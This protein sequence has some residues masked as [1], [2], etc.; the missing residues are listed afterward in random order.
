M[1]QG[2]GMQGLLGGWVTLHPTSGFPEK[3]GLQEQIGLWF[4]DLQSVLDPQ[5][6]GHTAAHFRLLGSQYLSAPQS[7]LSEHSS[8]QPS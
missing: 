1:P 7:E 8:E 2:L 6:P 4:A 3:P 5:K